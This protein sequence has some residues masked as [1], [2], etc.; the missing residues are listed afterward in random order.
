M[1]PQRTG[2]DS[3]SDA[4]RKQGASASSKQ[5]TVGAATAAGYGQATISPIEP[6]SS[7]YLSRGAASG[8]GP[9]RAAANAGCV[10]AEVTVDAGSSIEEWLAQFGEACSLALA[11]S[12]RD[13]GFD[14]AGVRADC[15]LSL[16]APSTP[17]IAY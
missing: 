4:V 13:A 12:F 6:A 2:P 7:S 9:V 3:T 14:S 5:T 1:Q 15:L 11:P 17:R 16:A 10:Q 8:G